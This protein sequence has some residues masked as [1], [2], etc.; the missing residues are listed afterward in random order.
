M[1]RNMNIFHNS[2]V[3]APIQSPPAWRRRIRIF[4]NNHPYRSIFQVQ[5][6]RSHAVKPPQPH[7]LL[8]MNMSA[9]GH[10]GRVV[11]VISGQPFTR[12]FLGLSTTYVGHNNTSEMKGGLW[13][14]CK[15]L[16]KDKAQ[17]H[18]PNNTTRQECEKERAIRN[19]QSVSAIVVI[20]FI[21]VYLLWWLN[22]LL[23]LSLFLI[24]QYAQLHRDHCLKVNGSA[25]A[26]LLEKTE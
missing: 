23:L 26:I 11:V 19:R 21:A 13:L 6:L 15:N 17:H 1:I 24:G 7:Q 16:R 12:G 10:T 2:T 25:A 3:A 22:Y 9:S 5:P 20:A 18:W 14:A 8:K 4:S